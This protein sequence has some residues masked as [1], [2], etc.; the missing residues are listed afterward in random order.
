MTAKSQNV[1]IKGTGID[2]PSSPPR[3]SRI[4]AVTTALAT[5]LAFGV[6]TNLA[7]G[8]LPGASNQIAN[9]IAVWTSVAFAVGALQTR[10]RASRLAG[11]QGLAAEVGLVAGYYGYAEF[12]REGM[13]A[14]LY[15]LIWLT[16]ACVAGP[17]MGLAGHWWRHGPTAQRRVVGL[18]MLTGTFGMESLMHAV[19]LNHTAVAWTGLALFIGIPQL[20]G[21]TLR[22][23]T[24][25]AVAAVLCALLGF[26]LVAAP[27]QA[28]SS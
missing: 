9:S 18:A 26:A 5:G 10:S 7:Q 28:I 14:L 27:L 12:G 25:A 20:L 8:W 24:L 21:R 22:E 11:L 19:Y 2:E 15:P 6:L 17:V 3:G 4:T 1:V 23:R 16:S 13:G